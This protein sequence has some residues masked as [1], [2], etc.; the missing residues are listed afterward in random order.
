DA[1]ASKSAGAGKVDTEA[2]F[3]ANNRGAALMEQYKPAQALEE[4]TRVTTTAPAWAPGQVNLGLAALYAR[5]MDRA[6]QAFQEAIRLDPKLVAGHYG[7]ATLQ[8]GQGQSA[9][10]LA[11][12]EAAQKLDPSDPDILYNIGLLSGRQRQF[13][14]AIESLRKAKELDPNSMSVRYQL[15]RALVQ[16][17]QA[18][19]G[20]KEMAAYQKLA[21]NPKFAVPTGNQYGEAGRH[22]LVITDYSGFGPPATAPAVA[23]RFRD[24]TT[25]SGIAFK[26][27]GPGGDG[28]PT[29]AARLGSGVA[30]GDLDGDGR[31]DLV[32]AD[33]SADGK[34]SPAIEKNR[35]G[36]RFEDVSAR[37]GVAFP[38]A[39]LA[40]ALGDYDNDGDLDLCLTGAS[41]AALFRNDGEGTFRDVSAAARIAVKGL[42]A[43][44]AWGDLDHD[45]DLD[46]LLARPSPAAGAARLALLRNRGYGTFE[47]ATSSL[48]VR[49]GAGGAIGAVFSDLDLDRDLD[50]VVAG[51]GGAD[52]LLDNRRE[53]GFA[54]AAGRAG[55]RAAGGG[56]GVAVGDVD[57]DGRPDLVFPAASPEG[58]ALFLGQDKGGFAR[59]DLP[60][61]KGSFYGAVLFDADNDGDLDLYL[62]GAGQVLLL[63]DGHGA[64][65]D[66]TSASGLGAI[67]VKDGR[68]AAAADLD[69][70]G[71]LDLV[72]SQNGGPALLLLN[73]TPAQNK[74]VEVAPHGLG[75]NRQA[76]GTK[77]EIQAG[78]SWQRREVT[79]GSGYLSSSAVPLHA[80]LGTRT[81]A[82]V[83]RLL[84]P[85]GVL[86]AELDVSSGQ[87]IEPQELD[88]KGSSCP[89][90]FAWDGATYKFVTDVLGVGGLG[91]WLAPGK[92]GTPVPDE[93]LAI[94]ATQ[95]QP[96]DGAYYFQVLE[97]LEEVTYL[98]AARLQVIDAP[99]DVE[100]VPNMNAGV[101]RGTPRL[102]AFE[103]TAK[104]FPTRAVDHHGRDVLDRLLKVDRTYPDEFRKLSLAGYAE[105]HDITMEFPPSIVDQEGYVLFLNGWTDFEYSSSNYA[106]SQQ[107]LSMVIPILEMENA[108]GI[109]QPVLEPMGFPPGMAR[110]IAVDLSS[111]GK[112]RGRRMRLRTNMRVYWD[113]IFLARPWDAATMDAR[114]QVSEAK[115]AAAHL[116]R[117]G[118]PREHSPDGKEP[119]LYDYRILDNTQPFRTMSGDYTRLG[120]VTD[121]V[122]E[123]DDLSVVFGKGEEVTLEFPVKGLPP[124]PKGTIRSFVLNLSGWCKDMDPHT[125]HGET[126]EPLPFRGMTSYPYAE[127]ESYPDDAAHK[128]Y[129]ATYNTRHLEGK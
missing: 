72:V 1:G 26:H 121:L 119:R 100:V 107:E 97:N 101:P 3:A 71:D 79:A 112:L 48:P 13:D 24:A 39:G 37:A 89:L 126:V 5:Q 68:G 120:R 18:A 51:V 117:R 23:A 78:P 73:D 77:I 118:F 103:R 61:A 29:E 32:L 31:I 88:R 8:K 55:L 59:R 2:L 15:A 47:E 87:R 84:W 129:R 54:E 30:I 14:R 53:D 111:L 27:G 20:E 38:S 25:A 124:A 62:C 66:A 76:V 28:K 6:A 42:V 80:G 41:G 21:A 114:L 56:R 109:F 105:M 81:V 50:I 17:G 125:A 70:D 123:A 108:D 67:A 7:L 36:G 96:L 85:G 9:E 22:A 4:F 92:Y 95:L 127:G 74:W 46:L 93:S 113:Q 12:F 99:K 86:Q 128:D 102:Y 52:T 69:G 34:G 33:V 110:T 115:A 19:E 116:H 98:D 122:T 49:P 43:G 63:N 57:G 104:V 65:G 83:V 45:G 106:A 90:L 91:T 44:A 64:F 94:S 75:S 10:A 82:D 11:E 35:G 60:A 40:A 16:S 58:T